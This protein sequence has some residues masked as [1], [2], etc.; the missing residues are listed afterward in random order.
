MATCQPND[1]DTCHIT[2]GPVAKK[3]LTSVYTTFGWRPKVEQ[4]YQKKKFH[5]SREKSMTIDVRCCAALGRVSRF[6]SSATFGIHNSRAG[7]SYTINRERRRRGWCM[8]VCV[9]K[10]FWV[11][12]SSLYSQLFFPFTPTLSSCTRERTFLPILQC[13][14][15][16]TRQDEICFFILVEVSTGSSKRSLLPLTSIIIIAARLGVQRSAVQ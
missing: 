12:S 9:W 10:E 16:F 6:A 8:C 2:S 13:T 4:G 15:S 14:S 1:D 7:Y 11:S 5:S 3:P